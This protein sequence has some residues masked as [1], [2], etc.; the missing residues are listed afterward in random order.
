MN[1]ESSTKSVAASVK[2]VIISVLGLDVAD[3]DD[4]LSLYSDAIG[5]DSLTLLHIITRIEQEL[6][7]E[8][9]DEAIMSA[10]LVNVGSLVELVNGL[11]DHR[12]SGNVDTGW[13][14]SGAR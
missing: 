2:Q 12:S 5:L 13:D 14:N 3:L 9:D 1:P 7:F 4:G 8:M 6:G 11:L 10:K